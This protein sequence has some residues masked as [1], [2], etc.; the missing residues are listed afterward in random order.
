[1]EIVFFGAI[2]YVVSGSERNHMQLRLATV[3]HLL[4][5]G[6]QYNTYFREGF[7]DVEE[8]VRRQRIFSSG[9]R[10]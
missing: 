10:S 7:T 5:H 2:S 8:Y 3:N 1:M 9:V 4:K 6:S